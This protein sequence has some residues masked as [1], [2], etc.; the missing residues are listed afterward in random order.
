ML[1]VRENIGRLDRR[2]TFQQKVYGTDASNQK[3]I[4]GWE[5]I[6]TTP[7][8]YAQVDEL[9]GQ[10]VIQAQQLTGLETASFL[11]RH[12]SDLTIENRIVY[13]GTY[14]DIHAIHQVGRKRFLKIVA[15]SGGQYTESD[16]AEDEGAFS[17]LN[18]SNAFS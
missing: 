8:V 14:W 2:I 4:T 17:D 1:N 15:E 18:F 9:S 10:E 7:T 3:L 13:D 6:S 12:R 16:E 5:N 11:I